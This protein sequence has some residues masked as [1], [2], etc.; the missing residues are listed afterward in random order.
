MTELD[1]VLEHHRRTAIDHR[2]QGDRFERLMARYLR[3]DPVYAQQFEEVWLWNQ[4]PFRDQL[5]VHDTG[6]DLV[7]KTRQGGY[8]AVQ[9][10]FFPEN[11]K[12]DKSAT[13]SFLAAS[14]RKFFDENGNEKR[15]EYRIWIS[16]TEGFTSH[17]EQSLHNQELPV[18]IIS[19]SDLRQAPVDW[20]KLNE[21]LF[22]QEALDNPRSLRPHQIEAVEKTLAHFATRDRGKLIMA[23]GTGKT[24]TALKIVE[25]FTQG[26]GTTLIL[27]PSIA[28][29]GQT[30]EEWVRYT[31]TPF[32]SILVCSDEQVGQNTRKRI[33]RNA[34]EDSS[35]PEDLPMPPST[36]PEQIARQLRANP[37]GL[38]VVF[39]TY[40]SIEAVAQAAQITGTVFDL[41]VCDEAHRTTGSELAGNADFSHFVKVHDDKFLP[42]RKRLYMTATP[43]LY[44]AEAKEKAKRND[45]Y[46]WSMDDETIYGPE[47]YRIGFAK[48]VREGL[49]SD[50]KVLILALNPD[51]V[52]QSLVRAFESQTQTAVETDELTKLVGCINALSMRL[53]GDDAKVLQNLKPMKRAVAFCATI[54]F[55]QNTANAFNKVSQAYRQ[56]FGGGQNG[57]VEVEADHIDGSMGAN[58][59]GKRMD[60][61][62][63]DPGEGKCRVLCNVRCLSEGVDVPALDAAIFVSAKNSHVEIVQSVGRVMR[64]AP[65]KE[66]GYVV[67]PIV[68]PPDV[69]PERA[70]D[71]DKKY[72]TVWTILNALRAH[73]DR[74]NAEVNKIELNRKRPEQ[75]LVLGMGRPDRPDELAQNPKLRQLA[76]AFPHLQ[77]AV[78]GKIVQKVGDR[79]YW[80]DWAQDVGKIAAKIRENFAALMRRQHPPQTLVHLVQSLKQ[81]VSPH[82]DQEQTLDILS[83][84]FVT[85]PVFNAL[86]G[87]DDFARQNPV[88]TAL[89]AVVQSVQNDPEFQFDSRKLN[90]FFDFV[91]SAVAGIDNPKGKQEIVRKLYES[92]FKTAFPKL[93]DQLGIVY[94]PVEIID[95]ILRSVDDLLKQRFG[96]SIASPDVHII[97]P[98]AGTGTFIV[99]LIQLGLMNREQLQHKYLHEIHAN[100]I[101]PLAY[102]VATVNIETAFLEAM[103]AQ[104]DGPPVPY[105]PFPGVCLTDTFALYQSPVLSFDFN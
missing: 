22:G 32:H 15:F 80:E 60:W 69:E 30:F 52:P 83:Q 39:S 43:R 59:R 94:T 48:A 75:I 40:H 2:D 55:S 79:R 78:Y 47:I 96:R 87:G 57:L 29:V 90:D 21:G 91:R 31:E 19:L 41:V 98:F 62:R 16:T 3:T 72:Q 4:F 70:L 101:V 66:Y 73:D 42:A 46:V 84:H 71:D 49:L 36:R 99:R 86:F 20:R 11:V 68:V 37:D 35:R 92:F 103:N 100:E 56:S 88:S 45:V 65:G 95:F 61:L 33:K 28:L 7:A 64:R 93:S 67:I 14:G 24:Y 44:N 6:I 102:Y 38:T 17:A 89:D 26:K 9:C 77:N 54:P 105:T 97:D 50:Y 104:N 51:E 53:V 1:W 81:F 63:E 76:L 85:L 8:V 74:F 12:I 13:D 58:Q 25:R 10:K 5:G 27:T 23:C 34:D 82:I 18:Q